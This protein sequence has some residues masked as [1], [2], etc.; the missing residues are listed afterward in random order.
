MFGFFQGYD[1]WFKYLGKTSTNFFNNPYLFYIFSMRF[2]FIYQPINSS[3]EWVYEICEFHQKKFKLPS[4]N[5]QSRSPYLVQDLIG[6]F[7]YV[8][9]LLSGFCCFYSWAYA[10]MNGLMY[11]EQIILCFF[12]CSLRESFSACVILLYNT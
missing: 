5:L 11:V 7:S 3:I 8:P 12:L 2:Q 6:G 10:F 9:C 1:Q 4:K